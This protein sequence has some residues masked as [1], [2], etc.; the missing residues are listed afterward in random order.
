MRAFKI[1]AA[2]ALLLLTGGKA[3]SGVDAD[4][5]F[6]PIRDAAPAGLRLENGKAVTVPAR[7][8]VLL[9]RRADPE[10]IQPGEWVSFVQQEGDGAP[11]WLLAGPGEAEVRQL[12]Q[13][14]EVKSPA[15]KRVG[16][17]GTCT[18]YTPCPKCRQWSQETRA[19][20]RVHPPALRVAEIAPSAIRAGQLM[21]PAANGDLLLVQDAAAGEALNDVRRIAVRAK[22]LER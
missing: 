21:V 16:G 8:K 4:L 17:I 14:A 11:L 13:A 1:V 10:A 2:A 22:L 18:L 19:K 15:A 5:I 7:T 3:W 12:V 6:A 9:V 20:R